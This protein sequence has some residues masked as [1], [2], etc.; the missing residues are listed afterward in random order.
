MASLWSGRSTLRG[1]KLDT[2][3]WPAGNSTNLRREGKVAT[4][5]LLP[6]KSHIVDV[7]LVGLARLK[8]RTRSSATA[9]WVAKTQEWEA[10]ARQ[11]EE[12]AEGARSKAVST[13]S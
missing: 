4:S 13:G 2:P 8:Y 3:C 6:A 11:F 10:L 1:A 7:Q 12:L 5:V 9:A